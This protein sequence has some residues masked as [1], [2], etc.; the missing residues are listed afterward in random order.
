MTSSTTKRILILDDDV[1][2]Q[3]MLKLLLAGEGYQVT[4]TTNGQEAISLYR[5]NLFDLVIIELLLAKSDGF[6][7]LVELRNTTPPPKFIATAKSGLMPPDVHL[8]M[9]RHLGAHETLSKPFVPEH[10]LI[11]VRNSLNATS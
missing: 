10:L 4:C 11:A 1:E 3:A 5:E 8:K 6:Q 7:T 9:A 2:M